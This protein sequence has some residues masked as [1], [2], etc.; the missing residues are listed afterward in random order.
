MPQ[1]KPIRRRALRLHLFV[2]SGQRDYRDVPI[3]SLCDSAA[4]ASVHRLEERSDEERAH[5]R[6]KVGER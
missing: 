1:R 6:R 2:A 4:D 3:C 5:E